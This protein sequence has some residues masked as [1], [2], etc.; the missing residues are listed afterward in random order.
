[1]SRDAALD[2]AKGIGIVLV[3]VGHCSGIPYWP[4]R[5][6][7]FSFHMPL[8]FLIGGYLYREKGVWESLKKDFFRLGLPYLATCL[9]ILLYFLVT[10]LWTGNYGI[11]RHYLSATC[12]GSGTLHKCRYLADVPSIGAIWF[13]PALLICKNV[14]NV[15][16]VRNRLVVSS[17]IFV[18]ATIIGRYLIYLP[19]SALSALSAIVFYAIGD[20][21]KT[22]RKIPAWGWGIGL[23]CWFLSLKYSR[24]FIVQPQLDLY[25]VDVIGATTAALLVY[26]IAMRISR[27]G[28]ISAFFQWL[29]A[30]SL[31]ILCL[32]L[33][34]MNCG[35]TNRF[36]TQTSIPFMFLSVLLPVSGA[37]VLSWLRR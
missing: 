17:I 18:L 31:L 20:R 29:G 1:M 36:F 32:H 22:V 35:I 25:F 10:S 3:I 14:Y 5:H 21:L 15:L 28:G 33:I 16:P 13:L 11:V 9:I 8:F 2:I 27:M 19:F 37:F 12:W 6:L 34:D 24:I 7:I 23:V 30:E 26:L 4:V